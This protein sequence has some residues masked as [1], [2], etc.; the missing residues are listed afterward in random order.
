MSSTERAQSA[1][2]GYVGRA[3]RTIEGRAPVAGKARYT[4][5]LAFDDM[6]PNGCVDV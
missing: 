2:G 1:T 4:D 5:D 3:V 6:W